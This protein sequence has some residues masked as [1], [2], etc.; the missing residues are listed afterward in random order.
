MYT[1]LTL[2]HCWTGTR[3]AADK[4]YKKRPSYRDLTF[5][6]VKRKSLGD[7]FY[8]CCEMVKTYSPIV[9]ELLN[10]MNLGEIKQSSDV[11]LS[12][13]VLQ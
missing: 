9:F 11:T 7:K 6:E 12:Y 5:P 8:I 4:M 2:T 10:F 1:T 3:A 13:L